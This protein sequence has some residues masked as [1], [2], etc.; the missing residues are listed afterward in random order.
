[1]MEKSRPV[2]PSTL[3]AR[4]S[5]EAVGSSSITALCPP[6]QLMK[7][8]WPAW[9]NWVPISR[10]ATPTRPEP[11]LASAPTRPP[12]SPTAP[13][14]P[15]RLHRL[16]TGSVSSTKPR[17]A[18]R[19]RPSSR[20]ASSPSSASTGGLPK[21]CTGAS[22]CG[23]KAAR[24]RQSAAV[25]TAS[26]PPS[27]WPQS[28]RRQLESGTRTPATYGSSCGHSSSAMAA[29]PACACSGPP[30]L[31]WVRQAEARRC[32]SVLVSILAS[33][34]ATPRSTTCRGR[35]WRHGD[36]PGCQP[37]G[38]GVPGRGR[39][40]LLCGTRVHPHSCLPSQL[41]APGGPDAHAPTW[42]A[43]QTSW[44]PWERGRRVTACPG[45]TQ[46]ARRRGRDG[47][48]GAARKRA[49]THGD[50]NPDTRV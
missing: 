47:R 24:R 46:E 31:S 42:P 33:R 41:G 11:A 37:R 9:P 39:G 5:G 10:A 34:Q 2:P 48:N 6:S 22:C 26:A 49:H 16:G 44:A 7:N 36:A 21:A 25:S 8:T 45:A 40:G 27:E 3:R 29:T 14:P 43:C 32:E 4:G 19:D 1:M 23:G 17:M 12:P 50:D 13:P 15:P 18:S 30:G 38:V 35:G 20:V 28:A